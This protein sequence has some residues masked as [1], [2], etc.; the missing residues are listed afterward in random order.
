MYNSNIFHLFRIVFKGIA[1]LFVSLFIMFICNCQQG[2]VKEQSPVSH[3]NILGPFSYLRKIV[4]YVLFCSD[5]LFFLALFPSL[6]AVCEVANGENL[7][8][9]CS[10]YSL[11]LIFNVTNYISSDL[12]M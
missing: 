1:N 10:F 2:P 4:V 11:S 9:C 8:T 6:H 12:V 5:F 7:S 3:F